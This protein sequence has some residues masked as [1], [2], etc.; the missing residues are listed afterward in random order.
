MSGSFD[1]YDPI[2]WYLYLLIKLTIMPKELEK[3]RLFYWSSISIFLKHDI[4]D[5]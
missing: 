3:Y 2:Y 4:Q 5:Y 1:F